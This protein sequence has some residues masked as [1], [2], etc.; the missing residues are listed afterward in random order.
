MNRLTGPPSQRQRDPQEPTWVL[1]IGS[2]SDAAASS[3]RSKLSP[4]DC[5]PL[6]RGGLQRLQL[7]FVV[8]GPQVSRSRASRAIRLHDLHGPRPEA[9]FTMRTYATNSYPTDP[10]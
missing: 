2:G 8:R 4:T 7:G 1:T 6:P 3:P 9:V 10:D 5:Q